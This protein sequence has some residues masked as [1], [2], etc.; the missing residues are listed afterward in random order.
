MITI[1]DYGMGNLRSVRKAFQECGADVSVSADPAQVGRADALV[2]PGVGAFGEAVKRL[3]ALGLREPVLEHVSHEKPLLGICLGMQLFF[4]RS[5]ENPEARGL[6]IMSGGL[7]RFPAGVKSPH[8]GWNDMDVCGNATVAGQPGCF[9][10]VHSYYVPESQWA[11]GLTDYSCRFVSA[12][13]KGPVV[14]VQFHPEKSQTA[15]LELIRR[16][17]KL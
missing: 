12:V 15:G 13:E 14:G 11:V 9:Y 5:E 6:S 4:D 2:L 1:V 7:K 17:L 8:I 10:F 16:F 3:D